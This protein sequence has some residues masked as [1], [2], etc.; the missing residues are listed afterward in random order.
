MPKLLR[1]L[2]C[3]MARALPH[4][5]PHTLLL[6]LIAALSIAALNGAVLVP[7]AAMVGG[8]P[9]AADGAGRSVVMI[10]GSSS[11][12]CTATAIAR[13]L[14]LTAAHCVLPGSDYKFADAAAPG[15]APTL[16]DILR[17][18]RD[19]QFDLHLLFVHV[20]TA[21]VALLKLAAPVPARVALSP[22][23]GQDE[24][25]SVGDTLVVAGYGV[26]TRGAERL[27]GLVRA[28]TLTVTGQPSSLQVRLYDPATKGASAGLGACTGD[29]GAPAF[30][31]ENG[32]LAVIGVVSWSTGPNL[33]AGCGGLTGITPLQR[34]R[35]WIVDT[36]KA[37]GSPLTQ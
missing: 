32:S 27:D 23:G 3:A 18:E 5:L 20:A 31:D 6:G 21:D 16:K 26:T 9:T 11:T 13:D 8:A 1:F 35:S 4:T 25:V 33:S 14:L 24:P 7:G 28:A 10:V 36:A 37:L 15:H 22:I 19:P 34:Y 17:I 2:A 30:R 29:S 12:V